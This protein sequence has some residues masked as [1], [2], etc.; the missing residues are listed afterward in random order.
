M[1]EDIDPNNF[2]GNIWEIDP[3]DV[4]R[5][6]NTQKGFDLAIYRYPSLV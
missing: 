6:A 1:D 5:N 3:K 2:E 4:V